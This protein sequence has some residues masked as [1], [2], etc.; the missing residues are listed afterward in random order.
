VAFFTGVGI[1]LFTVAGAVRANVANDV[2]APAKP[3]VVVESAWLV[4]DADSTLLRVSATPP[5][6]AADAAGG[7]GEQLFTARFRYRGEAPA[8]GLRI[9]LAVP[10]GL[11]YV[12]GS[13]TGPGVELSYSVDGGEAFAPAG[14][15]LAPVDPADPEAGMRAARAEDYS[16]IRWDLPGIFAPGVTGLVSFRASPPAPPLLADADAAGETP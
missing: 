16:H 8:H 7:G 1:A 10:A 15:L 13:A 6:E 12:A 4:M 14:E 3:D 11:R 5:E 9:V 2:P